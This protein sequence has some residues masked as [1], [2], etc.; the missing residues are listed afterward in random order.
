MSASSKLRRPCVAGL[1]E[2]GS[3]SSINRSTGVP[4]TIHFA[5]D[6]VTR[7]EPW[8]DALAGYARP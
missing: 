4:S 2:S 8:T 3:R 1:S 5:P 7:A 6:T